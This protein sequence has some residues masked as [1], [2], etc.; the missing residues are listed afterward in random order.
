MRFWPA[1]GIGLLM[2]EKLTSRCT[3]N[4]DASCLGPVTA[5]KDHVPAAA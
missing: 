5:S 4:R 2:Q 3:K 1:H